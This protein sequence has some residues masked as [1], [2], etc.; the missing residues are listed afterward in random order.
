MVVEAKKMKNKKTLT[1][2]LLIV[3]TILLALS[4]TTS[5]AAAGDLQIINYEGTPQIYSY[6]YIESLPKTY[7]QSD[8]YCYSLWVTGGNW[9]GVKLSELLASTG[10]DLSSIGSVQF[11]ASDGYQVKLDAPTALRPDVIVAYEK[12]DIPLTETY[13]LVYP[14]ANGALWVSMITSI[15]AS[16][17]PIEV[18]QTGNSNN[19]PPA[20]F[21]NNNNPITSTPPP[22]HTTTNQPTPT[23]APTNNS[24]THPVAPPTNTPET[25]TDTNNTQENST[26]PVEISFAAVV[27]VV[28]APVAASFVLIRRRVHEA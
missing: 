15:T 25:T 6:T 2:C 8:L 10:V 21:T 7:V 17:I 22:S 28:A 1:T 11:I 23:P 14:G 9:G 13:R 18:S 20:Q 27:A 26:F 24:I 4:Q 3:A 16:Q 19:P 12:D 5:A